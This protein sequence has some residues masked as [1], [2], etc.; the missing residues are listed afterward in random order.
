VTG[1]DE[2]SA[3]GGQLS[4]QLTDRLGRQLEEWRRDLLAMDRRQRLLYFTHTRTASLELVA[5]EL[6]AI[7][8][9]VRAG[10][11]PIEVPPSVDPD[12]PWDAAPPVPEDRLVVGNKTEV[13]LRAALR[14]LDQQSQQ[15][16]A[17][18]GFWTLYLGLGMVQ[19]LD[20][21]DGRTVLS[22]LLL[23]PVTVRRSATHL[24]YEV[25]RTEDEV[26]VNPV[27]R[28]KLDRDF[29]VELP[30][31]EE[32][33]RPDIGE[34]L[35]SVRDRVGSRPGW[36][37]WPRAVMTTFSFHKEAIYKDLLEHE[38]EVA[39]SPLVQLLALGPDAPAAGDYSFEPAPDEGIDDVV[40]PERLLSILD[41]DGSQRKCILAAK[42]GRSFV[43]DGP[44]GT[45]KSQTIA[46]I[47]VELAA[48][49]R[50][51]LFVS[52][53]AAALDV[54]RRR[55]REAGLDQFLLELHSHAATRKQVAQELGRALSSQV[56]AQHRFSAGDEASLVDARRRLTNY[57]V[58]MNE[59]RPGLGRTLHQVLGRLAELHRL[60]DLSISADAGWAKLDA[61]GLA[62]IQGLAGRL[63]RAWR[64]V[65]AGSEFLWR[66]LASADP[67]AGEVQGLA[68]AAAA[69]AVESG[70]LTDR[71]TAI[72]R[73]LGLGF[74]PSLPDAR[75]RLAILELVHA[76]P[77]APVGWLTTDL[78]ALQQRAE[79]LR[80]ATVAHAD[81]TAELLRAAGPRWRELD[82]ELAPVAGTLSRAGA[83][84]W[85][86]AADTPADVLARAT[87]FLA[88]SPSLLVRV[89]EDARRL[90]ATF[91][92]PTGG[93]SAVRAA[94]LA[95]LAGLGTGPARPE[96]AW[97]NPAVQAALD[98]STRV[99]G[100]LVGLVQQRERSLA[101]VFTRDALGLD[102]VALRTRFTESHRGFGRFSKQARD[103][104][105]TLKD[106]TVA[107]KVT[108]DVLARLDEAVA[109]QQLERTLS[110][111]E[112]EHAPL[113]GSYYRRTDTDFGRVAAAVRTAHRAVRLAGEDLNAAAVAQQLALG[114][115]ADP[116]APIV[117]GR[118]AGALGE[119]RRELATTLGPGLAAEV[120]A[121]PL[122]DA[123]Q[124]CAD[125]FD[126]LRPGAAAV[127]G[128]AEVARRPVTIE[129]AV[130]LLDRAAE[131]TRSEAEILDSYDRD[132]EMLGDGYAGLDTDW[133]SLTAALDWA[134]RLQSLTAGP[135]S[136]T[137]AQRLR[138]PT[139]SAGDL[140][141]LLARWEQAR[142]ELVAGFTADRGGTLGQE[143]AADLVA[144]AETAADMHRTAAT[145]I[146]E[147]AQHVAT[148][149][150]LAGAGFLSVLDDLARRRCDPSVVPDAIERAALEAWAAATVRADERLLPTRA[151]DRDALVDQFRRLDRKLVDEA[152]AAVVTACSALRP[153]TA[154]SRAAQVI[155]R[156][157]EKK[158]RHKPIR[159]LLTEAGDI[160]LR[161]KPCF[162]MS[163]LSVSQYLPPG[164]RFDVVIF[165]EASQVLPSDAINCVYRGRQLI[166]AGDQKQLPPTAF[167]ARAVDDDVEDED[168]DLDRFQSVLDLCKAAG[169]L[170]SL[171]LT[172]HY[173]SQ[174]ES[175]ITYSNYRF[176]GG[177]LHT[178]PGAVFRAPD[179]GVEAVFAAG[180][181]R[182]GGARDNPVEADKV[183]ERILHHRREHPER[184]IGV[185]TFSG[186]QEDAVLA[187][188]ERVPELSGLLADRD[189]LNGFF[190]KNLENVQGDERDIV[191]FSV[192]YGPDEHGKFTM[193][194]GPLN[195]EGGWR[196]LNVAV[197]R[198]RRR[199]EI[200][201]SFRS[202]DV[203][204]SL[205]EGVR[206]LKGYLDFAERG[207]AA[208]SV[209][210]NAGRGDAESPFEEDVLRV[211]GSLGY[212]AEPQVG[213]AGYRIDIGVKHPERPGSYLLAVECDGA[214]Y[215]SARAARD[216]DRLREAVLRGLGWRIH[217]IWGLSWV[218]DRDGQIARLRAAIE[219]ALA[220]DTTVEPPPSRE[221]DRLAAVVIEEAD[222]G[223]VPEWAVPYRSGAGAPAGSTYPPDAPEARP[224][225]RS[226]V[227]RVLAI[228]APVHEDLLL[229]AVRDDWGI[230]RIG[231][232]IRSNLDKALSAARVDGSRVTRDDFGFYR[233]EG[234]RLRIVR[235]PADKASTRTV[236][237]VPPEELDLSISYVVRDA[238]AVESDQVSLAVARLFGWGRQGGDIRAAVASSIFRLVAAGVLNPSGSTLRL[239][240]R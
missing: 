180:E 240:D 160:A 141:P 218:R 161:L 104:R 91:G 177:K 76:W 148:W 95:E 53:K 80:T 126:E 63:S 157:A 216:R 8:S 2:L 213:A 79:R 67:E 136:E 14:R 158:S 135:V 137:V 7:E 106:A 235:V 169:A 41:A 144:A 112:H 131:I 220:A 42:D 200:V 117:A 55:L 70:A 94:E 22:P 30:D 162:M 145:D 85:R 108:K 151:S 57:A 86:P 92:M 129:D 173:R 159:Q 121:V 154:T 17:D 132:R 123:A 69:V 113:L 20:P 54:V 181:Y 186:A 73:D 164:I 45:G 166:V 170:P 77:S 60:S 25:R 221:P 230:G 33:N 13:E 84:E 197:T 90:A 64:P 201:S 29:G 51:V 165:D 140:A 3:A 71:L 62:V 163:P 237:Q 118:L 5:P 229:R 142:D 138:S 109:W 38:A 238:V 150:G 21:E 18:R 232:L 143:L 52:E 9:L 120:A 175:L 97:I 56:R 36:D 219:D 149:R 196:R 87:A 209:D 172:W 6:L 111:R 10:R 187:A 130:D 182:R 192:G 61:A 4:P 39:A 223:A 183:V 47:I 178:F 211:V 122:P 105:R 1:I 193:N 194:F 98:E 115:A 224:Y 28:Q 204:A 46:N 139:F 40:P 16:Y 231:N 205:S 125:R 184:S 65:T 188:L 134:S 26:V 75:R 50:S 146:D 202:N 214:A 34:L 88:S 93:L 128:V 155:T 15:V 212:A 147:W 176:Y 23:V 174:H 233:I 82:G 215:H 152:H 226:Y 228:E 89:E 234:R 31:D 217:R 239:A 185:V 225:L 48:T 81:A 35:A 167:F 222:L 153:R 208:L 37:V 110:V 195:R 72:D 116:S 227:E 207:M 78:V 99:L 156:E 206:H 66:D 19:W 58:A 11:T 179:L 198:A 43:M 199:V 124:W 210:V 103:D 100:E 191:I 59:V 190:V 96:P 68:R 32:E 101:A 119:W 12:D 83:V 189:R 102:L 203:G 74:A 24:P 107:R 27:L 44:P 236:G 168:A 133:P 49:G 114:A 171:P 127:Q